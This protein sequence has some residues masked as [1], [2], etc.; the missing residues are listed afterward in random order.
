MAH[1]YRR[2]MGFGAIVVLVAAAVAPAAAADAPEAFKVLA[3]T[4]KAMK[5]MKTEGGTDPAGDTNEDAL[6]P[7]AKDK[8]IG[9]VLF[10]RV[11]HEPVHSNTMPRASERVKK[12]AI[13]ASPGEFEPVSVG[14]AALEDLAGI[15]AACGE[16]EGPGGAKITAA[17]ID[18]RYATNLQRMYK[19]KWLHFPEKTILAPYLLEKLTEGTIAKGRTGLIWLTVHVPD[20]AKPGKYHGVMTLSIKGKDARKIRVELEVLPI[21]LIKPKWAYLMSAHPD[22]GK[23]G[24]GFKGVDKQMTR[25]FFVDLAAHGITHI[26]T[27]VRVLRTPADKIT[28][29]QLMREAER[30]DELLK[31]AK[32]YGL[33]QAFLAFYID[34]I[35]QWKGRWFEYFPLSEELDAGYVRV[36]KK[37]AAEAK[38]RNWGTLYIMPGDEPGGHP[39]TMKPIK[40]YLELLKEQVPEVKTVICIGGGMRRGGIGEYQT[41]R[42]GLDLPITS[43]MREDLRKAIGDDGKAFWVYG[44]AGN[45]P[46][47]QA[48]SRNRPG[49]YAAAVKPAGVLMW[50]YHWFIGYAPGEGPV[51]TIPWEMVR[52]G[53]DD[54]RYA[55]TLEALIQEAGKSPKPGA[56]LAARAAKG[57]LQNVLGKIDPVYGDWSRPG[58]NKAGELPCAPCVVEWRRA[59]A[60]QIVELQDVL[61]QVE[62]PLQK[63]G[64]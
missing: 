12:L 55:A 31:L 38:K 11:V 8:A 29:K 57:I 46:A 5:P 60:D 3:D 15:T 4:G 45:A 26:G 23:S 58:K 48:S 21:R 63:R 42:K 51:P 2:S 17:H 18:L 40:H 64:G 27:S 61:K 16:L 34:S 44:A 37:M 49:F 36:V 53:I 59:I 25:K 22:W 43:L 62:P 10:S 54:A 14:I 50:C 13:F 39:A 1:K 28:D 30:I 7:T 41:L 33:E 52:E 19:P 47:S 24:F 9:Y 6:T 35:C 56:K 20:N 32:Q